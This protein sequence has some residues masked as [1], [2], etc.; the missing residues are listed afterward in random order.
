M[1]PI[2]L[3]RSNRSVRAQRRHRRRQERDHRRDGCWLRRRPDWLE[4]ITAPLRTDPTVCMVGGYYRALASPLQEAIAAATV[5]PP[6]R[7]DPETFLPSSRS[8]A[9]RGCLGAGGRLPGVVAPQRRH[10][11][12]PALRQAGCRM[13][14]VPGGGGLV[15]SPLSTCAGF[16]SSSTAM[17]AATRRRG[18]SSRTTG[19]ASPFPRQERPT[20]LGRRHPGLRAARGHRRG[21]LSREAVPARG[22]PDT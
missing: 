14:F 21:T 2:L 4:R 8:L 17:R 19:K 12:C 22:A 20:S 10:H 9:F 5:V 7:V 1:R 11:L 15:G 16:T 13:A 18:S 3:P 6:E